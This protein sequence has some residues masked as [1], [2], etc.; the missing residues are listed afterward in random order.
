MAGPRLVTDQVRASA[1]KAGLVRLSCAPVDGSDPTAVGDNDPRLARHSGIALLDFGASPGSTEA[2]ITIME[3]ESIV[4][5]SVCHA[6]ILADQTADHSLS[7]HTHAA[8]VVG[9]SCSV[10]VVGAGFTIYARSSES[11]QGTFNVQWFWF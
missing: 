1:A 9:L 5:A 11:L 2:S 10:P 6:A 4:A 7:D 3:Q 8:L